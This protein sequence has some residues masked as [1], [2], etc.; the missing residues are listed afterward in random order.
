MFDLTT[1][2]RNLLTRMRQGEDA[3]S[4]E[5]VILKSGQQ[6]RGRVVGFV[7]DVGIEKVVVPLDMCQSH[8]LEL[9][10]KGERINTN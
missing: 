5:I 7:L 6:I 9:T 8:R 3:P 4:E 10:P 1:R 2:I